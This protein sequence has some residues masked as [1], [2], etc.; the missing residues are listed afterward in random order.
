MLLLVKPKIV[1]NIALS[2][3]FFLIYEN[4]KESYT[5]TKK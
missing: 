1:P 5:T 2:E 3:C 4:E